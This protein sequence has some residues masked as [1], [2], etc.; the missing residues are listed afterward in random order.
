MAEYIKI[1]DAVIIADY[2]IDEHPYDK[3][4]KKPETFSDYNRGWNDAC[5]YIRGALERKATAD[6]EGRLVVLPCRGWLDIAFGDQTL[7]WGIDDDYIENPIRGI[8]VD[9]ADRITWYE[10][11]ETLVGKGFD[12]NGECWL[13]SGHEIGKTVFLTR[14]E[15]EQALKEVKRNG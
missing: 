7:F 1:A 12:E 9:D 3:D 6:E 11:W 8:S 15:A 10:G 4:P 2:A 13:F 14:E 5:D